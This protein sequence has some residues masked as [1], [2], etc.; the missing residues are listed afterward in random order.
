MR[1]Q[2]RH[3][4]SEDLG[5]LF[6]DYV[7]VQRTTQSELMALDTHRLSTTTTSR[8]HLPFWTTPTQP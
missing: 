4:L 3:E 1:V 8:Y 7:R 2:F 6:E 5:M